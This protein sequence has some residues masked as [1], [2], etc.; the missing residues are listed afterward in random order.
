MKR[1]ITKRDV[2]IQL[3]L[4]NVNNTKSEF[5]GKITAM[6]KK[7]EKKIEEQNK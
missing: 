6:E 2:Q 7:H 3:L 1:E 5:N 4:S